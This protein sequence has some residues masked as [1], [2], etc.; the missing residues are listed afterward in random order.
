MAGSTIVFIPELP[1][2][3]SNLF[4]RIVENEDFEQIELDCLTSLDF[5]IITGEENTNWDSEQNP[6]VFDEDR[7]IAIIH[8]S[9]IG[10]ISV[11][12]FKGELEDIDK[13]KQIKDI[14]KLKEFTDKYGLDNLYELVTF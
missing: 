6:I 5:A 10:L 12:Q 4:V 11:L 7:G 14:A 2:D 1:Q 8:I 13:E 3:V 9:K